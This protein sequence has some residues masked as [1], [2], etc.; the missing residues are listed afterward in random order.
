MMN[1]DDEYD[2]DDNQRTSVQN[3]E[4]LDTEAGAACRTPFCQFLL[5]TADLEVNLLALEEG[6]DGLYCCPGYL[7]VCGAVA[8]SS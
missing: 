2:D 5:G 3:T 4:E 7:S 8:K 6:T 1:H